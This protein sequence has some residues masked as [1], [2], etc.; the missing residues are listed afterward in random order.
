MGKYQA[1]HSEQDLQQPAIV[2]AG[3]IAFRGFTEK[4]EGGHLV[5]QV[6]PADFRRDLAPEA[7]QLIV[8]FW[9]WEGAGD[10]QHAALYRASEAWHTT[11]E[12]GFPIDRLRAMLGR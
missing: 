5:V 3:G 1:T 6:D 7:A 9:R 11:F 2:S 10:E 12:H 4:S 8:L